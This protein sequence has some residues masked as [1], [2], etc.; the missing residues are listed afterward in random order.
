MNFEDLNMNLGLLDGFSATCTEVAV[1]ILFQIKNFQNAA[2]G[3]TD[4]PTVT[5]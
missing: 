3:L 2:F 5:F 1:N 4:V